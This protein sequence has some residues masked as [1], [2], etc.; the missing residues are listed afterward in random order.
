V[1]SSAWRRAAIEFSTLLRKLK[2]KCE[3]EK[4][5]ALTIALTPE[6]QV[7]LAKERKAKKAAGL[8]APALGSRV[9]STEVAL[10]PIVAL[11][12][13]ECATIDPYRACVG[14]AEAAVERGAHL[15]ENSPVRRITFN[16]KIADVHLAGGKIRTRKVIVATGT[17]PASVISSTRKEPSAGP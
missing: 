5:T 9:V 6:Q 15:Y 13:R 14:L 11:R 4:T 10:S 2:I 1:N 3:L 12:G 17:P 8:D 7:R 16:R